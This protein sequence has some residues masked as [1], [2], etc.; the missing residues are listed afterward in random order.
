LLPFAWAWRKSPAQRTLLLYVGLSAVAWCLGPH[1]LR[2]ALFALPAACL[3]AAHAVQE[4]FSWA[5]SKGWAQAWQALVLAGLFAGAAQCFVLL[6]TGFEPWDPALGL[7]DPVQYLS[8]H[9]IPQA[10]AA[11][12]IH[13]R[14]LPW[15]ILLLGDPR[16]AYLP[17]DTLACSFYETHP[18]KAWVK[19]AQDAAD[20]GAIVRRKGYDFLFI[21]RVEWAALESPDDPLYW[22]HGDAAA[23]ARFKGWVQHLATEP[24]RP[25]LQLSQ[26]AGWVFDL[27]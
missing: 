16:T 6:G 25:R 12:W 5:R 2:F 14:P 21:N 7:Q 19:E 26:G 11:D 23:E 10:E 15:H 4:G 20:L 18:L 24:G 9:Q 22:D 3:L 17:P 27:R 1:V 8:L 13:T